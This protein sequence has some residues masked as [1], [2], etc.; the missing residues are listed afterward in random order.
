MTHRQEAIALMTDILQNVTGK[1]PS[2]TGKHAPDFDVNILQDNLLN[3]LVV[4]LFS[5][6]GLGENNLTRHP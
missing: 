6:D 1:P 5:V 4:V 2:T 3:K